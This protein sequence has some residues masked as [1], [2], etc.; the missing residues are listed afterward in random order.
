MEESQDESKQRSSQPTQTQ[1]EV[2]K[3]ISD[4]FGESD[5]DEEINAQPR[6]ESNNAGNININ[7]PID[8]DDLFSSDDDDIVVSKNNSNSS[9]SNKKVF[10]DAAIFGSDDDGEDASPQPKRLRLEKGK[11]KSSKQSENKKNE[12]KLSSKK[13]ANKSEPTK[14]REAEVSSKKSEANSTEVFGSDSEDSYDSGG[15]GVRTAADDNFIDQEDENADL[16][17]EYNQDV[18]HFD[19]ERPDKHRRHMEREG[20]DEDESNPLAQT[21]KG[22]KKR[23]STDLSEQHKNELAQDL[24]KMM[25]KAAADDVQSNLLG[26]PAVCKLNMLAKVQRLAGVK[27]LQM[28]L[29]DFDILGSLKTWIEPRDKSAPLAGLTVRT[30]VYELLRRLPCQMDHLKRSGIGKVLIS[31]RQNE[32]ETPANKRLI[33][34]IVDK[35]CRPIFGKSADVRS[36]VRDEEPVEGTRPRPKP[37]SERSTEGQNFDVAMSAG[38]VLT[39]KD[40]YSRVQCPRNNGFVFKV[41]PESKVDRAAARESTLSGTKGELLKRMKSARGGSKANTRAMQV[42]LSG[43]N[44][45]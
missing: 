40:P 15:E 45:A 20:V 21:L 4:I 9:S 8:D 24:L 23:K 36:A 38:V 27:S 30:A 6:L 14:K 7:P 43:R 42:A 2:N 26:Q 28:T 19:D 17:A 41:R 10:D 3:L 35:W 34:D 32:Q 33:K 22:M 39:S 31:L 12:G 37:V 13:L 16:V 29:L 1:P 18:Q 5:D 11:P 25:D 44:K